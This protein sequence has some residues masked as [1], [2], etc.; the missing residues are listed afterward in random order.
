M[1]HL[2][3]YFRNL[4]ARL[5]DEEKTII[6]DCIFFLLQITAIFTVVTAVLLLFILQP[7]K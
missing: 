2:T 4:E 1:K 5:T 7:Y 3:H 6:K